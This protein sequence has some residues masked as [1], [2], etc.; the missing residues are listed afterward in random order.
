M[1]DD[2]TTCLARAAAGDVR[3]LDRFLPVV[4]GELRAL[5]RRL[6]RPQRPGH[7]L[8]PT[9]LVHEAYLKLVDQTAVPCEARTHFFGLAASAMRQVLVDHAR[10]KA[11]DKRGGGWTRISI[12]T[13]CLAR[14]ADVR[15]GVD[16]V[17]LNDALERLAFSDPR[18]ARVVEL[19]HFAGLT[20]DET[21]TL[22]H[23]SASTVEADWRYARA[24]LYDALL[25][26]E[27]DREA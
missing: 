24:W 1:A 13:A 10:R 7:T 26:G 21:A 12:E 20:I 25:G 23:V 4:Y 19:R 15:D 8:T 18:A 3:A 27:A 11:A 16:L 6:L 9:A 2:L 5:A 14:S 17:A 22:L